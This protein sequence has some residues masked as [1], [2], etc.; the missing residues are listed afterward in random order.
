MQVSWLIEEISV[1]TI[2]FHDFC[3]WQ[4]TKFLII[5][6]LFWMIVFENFLHDRQSKFTI[7]FCYQLTKFSIYFHNIL[8]KSQFSFYNRFTKFT[9]FFSVTDWR[10]LLFF[11]P[12]AVDE[13]CRFFLDWLSKFM[14]FFVTDWQIDFAEF[15][16]KWIIIGRI[17]CL[18]K[19]L[20]RENPTQNFSL[21]KIFLFCVRFVQ[22]RT[23]FQT[24]FN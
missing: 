22:Y 3:L 12:W 8:T 21:C 5:I 17:T 16:K 1:W 10:N 9:F 2:K 19:N 23:L 15:C 7:F 6:F 14:I 4:L 20:R 18:K 24:L 11:F 13:I